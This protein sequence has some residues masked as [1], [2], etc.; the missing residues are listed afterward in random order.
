[1]IRLILV[2]LI[3]IF[4]SQLY[5][6]IIITPVN[7]NLFKTSMR[8]LYSVD[9]NITWASG[10]DGVIMK[11]INN[12]DWETFRNSKFNHLDFRDIHA[13][14]NNE[15][16]IMSS[17]DGCEIYKTNNDGENWVKVYENKEKGIFFDGMDF[18]DNKNGIAMS[19]PINEELYI[20][21]TKDGGETWQKL[22][23][24]NLPKTLKGEACFAASGTG[25]NCVGDSTV[26]IG[27]GGSEQTRV[28]ISHNRG[29][30]WITVNT[31][32]R[33]GEASG[34]YSL[35]FIDEINGVAVG[36][37]YLDSNTTLGNCAI[38][39]DGGKTW[40]LPQTPPEGY[41][42][43]VTANK[44]GILIACGRT[45]VDVSYD[46]GNNWKHISNEGYYSCVLNKN[47]GWLVGRKGK[48]AKISLK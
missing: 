41:K 1:M 20:I 48:M 15:A 29:L 16:I 23:V 17:G 47:S 43:C 37:N 31:P 9:E 2:L 7:T 39:S 34:I 25:I 21:E 24:I 42:S 26:Y 4:T 32:M 36:G 8:G 45:G 12:N 19:D 46:R 22:K 40:V 30:S 6:Q 18:W 14:N 28:F 35:T 10:T 11:T 27:T 38:T 13:L 33:K 44:K 5:S 3:S